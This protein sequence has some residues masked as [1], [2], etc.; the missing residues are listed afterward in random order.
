MA[1]EIIR[2]AVFGERLKS[3]MDSYHENT[4]TMGRIFHLSPPSISRYTRGEMAPKMTTVQQMAAYFDVNPHWL[5][6]EA[7]S[8][9]ETEILNADAV[10]EDAYSDVAVFS[11][12]SYDLPI[13][14][15]PRIDATLRL[16]VKQLA[17]WGPVF[18]TILPDDSMAPTLQKGDLAILKLD[19]TLRPGAALAIHVNHQ[20]MV[21]RKLVLQDSEA[22]LQPH[23][24]AWDAACYHLGRDD[25]Q[26]IGHV[27]YCKRTS[28]THFDAPQEA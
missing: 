20:D 14:S 13:F 11:K 12:V 2:K 10:S 1:D 27:V 16:P 17:K 3:L 7:V 5:M 28:E 6:G 15:N 4:Y 22:I 21:I 23:N 18:A 25:I 8:M 9:Y 19:T 26:V 24:P